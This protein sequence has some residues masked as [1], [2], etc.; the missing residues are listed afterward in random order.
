MTD[1]LNSKIQK[2][3]RIFYEAKKQLVYKLGCTTKCNKAD[4]FW[5]THCPKHKENHRIVVLDVHKISQLLRR[6][7]L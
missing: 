6:I 4:S 2:L 3:L 5:S 1:C 7:F